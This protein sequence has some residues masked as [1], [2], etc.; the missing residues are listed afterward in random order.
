MTAARW[1]ALAILVTTLAI[2][3]IFLFAV[4]RPP[5]P[6]EEGVAGTPVAAEKRIDS[7]Q[8]VW[9]LAAHAVPRPDRTVGVTVTARDIGGAAVDARSPPRAILRMLDMEMEDERVVLS[10]DGPGA[11]RGSA[12]L[13]M[14]GRWS[15]EVRFNGESVRVAF[16]AVSL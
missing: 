13:S 3:G 14:A 15:L 8:G 9:I 12:R 5:A 2:V 16:Q 7:P 11:W 4:I 10:E 6:P 1:G